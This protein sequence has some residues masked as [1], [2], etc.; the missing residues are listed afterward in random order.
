MG[1]IFVF[2]SM[3]KRQIPNRTTNDY[4][5]TLLEAG[6]KEID[7]L[8]KISYKSLETELV[9]KN[10]DWNSLL[11]AF[12]QASTLSISF[13]FYPIIL[14]ISGVFIDKRFKTSPFFT[15]SGIILGIEIGRAHV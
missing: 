1:G 9:R 4:S 14:L 8:D 3:I 2:L 13:V 6:K 5:L 10:L 15:I 12:A 7:K 11:N